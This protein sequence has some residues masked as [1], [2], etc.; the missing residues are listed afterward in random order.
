M[1]IIGTTS[2]AEVPGP[3]IDRTCGKIFKADGQW[4]LAL[5][6]TSLECGLWSRVPHGDAIGAGR[7]IRSSR[8][9]CRQRDGVKPSLGVGVTGVRF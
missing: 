4:V 8:P 2:I 9:R 6:R 3:D 5:S 1:L 7:S